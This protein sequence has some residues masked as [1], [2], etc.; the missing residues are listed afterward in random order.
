[1]KVLIAD[2][3]IGVR[4]LLRTFLARAGHEVHAAGDGQMAWELW[5]RDHF[6]LV[7]TDWS[8]PRVEGPEL[9]SRIRAGGLSSYTYIILLTVKQS[10]NDVVAG[11]ESGADDYLTK[12]FNPRELM[13]RVA[14]GER[15][16]TLQAR[17]QELATRD[18]L[19]GL[20]NRRTLDGRLEDE[21]QRAARYGRPLS[22]IMLDLDHFK[23]Y[24][25]TH[26]HPQGD[27]LLCEAGQVIQASVRGTDVVARYGGEEFVV[28]LPETPAAQALTV[29][30]NVRET[31]AAHTF[32]RC[33]QQ[34]GGRLTVS[35]GVASYPENVGEVRQLLNRADQALYQAKR[36]GRDR[37][38]QA[39]S[40][41]A[42]SDQLV[43]FSREQAVTEQRA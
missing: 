9:I 43:H 39:M 13:A 36:S 38:V 14:I 10:R 7:L 33:E 1:M 17:L 12:P 2:D 20:F 21:T 3:D 29:A 22:L 30:K 6:Q 28:I 19:T 34:P 25:D 27:I 42:N 5:Q 26:G 4:S 35:L 15:M 37:V 11:L 31:I 40:L 18:G 32:P 16:L 23:S 8:M 41:P 24:N